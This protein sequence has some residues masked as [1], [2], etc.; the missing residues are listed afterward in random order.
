MVIHNHWNLTLNFTFVLW[1]S[2]R[3]EDGG[4]AGGNGKFD[5][6]LDPLIVHL[7][8]NPNF[9]PEVRIPET[10]GESLLVGKITEIHFS[11]PVTFISIP[12][13][14]APPPS[15]NCATSQLISSACEDVE[16]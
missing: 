11:L 9:C 8:H 13:T 5:I 1:L 2:E 14:S 10:E 7:V 15:D 3:E 16:R 12:V 4:N 6:C